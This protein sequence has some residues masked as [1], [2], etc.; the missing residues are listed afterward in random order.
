MFHPAYHAQFEAAELAITKWGIEAP[1]DPGYSSI[2]H[3]EL[4][5]DVINATKH[6]QPTYLG[7]IA[8]MQAELRRPVADG[9]ANVIELVCDHIIDALFDD[10]EETAARQIYTLSQAFSSSTTSAQMIETLGEQTGRGRDR[11]RGMRPEDSRFVTLALAS[12]ARYY[13]PTF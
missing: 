5:E 8:I 11:T 4:S 9:E 2:R 3:L 6:F 13:P 12:I 1:P 10:G 7:R